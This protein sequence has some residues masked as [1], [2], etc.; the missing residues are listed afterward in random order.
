MYRQTF[1]LISTNRY[2][3]FDMRIISYEANFFSLSNCLRKIQN[4]IAI[5]FPLNREFAIVLCG[6]RFK[7]IFQQ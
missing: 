1:F 7:K 3:L 2:L 6:K 5:G 4:N